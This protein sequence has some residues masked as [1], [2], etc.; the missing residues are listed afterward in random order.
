MILDE[1]PGPHVSP[2]PP[3]PVPQPPEV[4]ELIQR[5]RAR[6]ARETRQKRLVHLLIGVG[7]LTVAGGGLL[8]GVMRSGRATPPGQSSLPAGALRASAVSSGE[9]ELRAPPSEPPAAE[10]TMAAPTPSSPPPPAL[11]ARPSRPPIATTVSYQP[12]QRLTTLRAGDAKE[13][14]FELF[15]STVERRNGSLVRIEGMRLRA[16]GRSSRY[17]Q[18]EVA[19]VKVADAGAG[20]VY[21]FL[22]GDG[23]LVGWGR[24]EEWPATAKRYEVEIDY[25]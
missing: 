13:R 5:Y 4:R 1:S 10:K 22:F 21:W 25:R 24:P 2:E 16:T 14:V 15:G 8:M 17:A 23:R 19:E 12:R 3:A 18:V 9:G 6:T 20:G 7:V 11:A